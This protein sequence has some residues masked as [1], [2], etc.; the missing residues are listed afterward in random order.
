MKKLLCTLSVILAMVLLLAACGGGNTAGEGDAAEPVVFKIAQS[1]TE[2]DPVQKGFV[3]FGELLEERTEGRYK[4]EIFANGVLGTDMEITEAVQMGNIDIISCHST[5]LANF[6]PIW[7]T[8]DLPFAF[9]TEELYDK[10]VRGDLRQTLIDAT[11]ADMDNVVLLDMWERGYR[12][13]TCNKPVYSAADM[14]GVR[15]RVMENALH[16]GYWAMVGADPATLPWA[17][18]YVALQQKAM[19]AHDNATG[20]IVSANLNEVQDYL[21]LSNHILSSSGILM[22]AEKF[23]AMSAEDQ[24][25]VKECMAEAG[26]YQDTILRDAVASDIEVLKERGMN[27]LT[28]EE[29]DLDSFITIAGEFTSTLGDQYAAAVNFFEQIKALE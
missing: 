1:L 29:F 16:Q 19:D 24:E 20:L 17:D 14:Q 6:S 28:T 10:V 27:V 12:C 11:E 13:L 25:I 2:K 9:P 15:M 18:V 8:F 23:N 7:Y 4:V 22:N 3:K 26:I 5:N 21:M